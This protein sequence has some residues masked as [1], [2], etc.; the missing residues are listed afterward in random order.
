MGDGRAKAFALSLLTILLTSLAGAGCE[1]AD[2][3]GELGSHLAAPIAV[4]VDAAGNRAYVVNSNN[5]QEFDGASLTVLDISIPESPI[6]LTSSSNPIAIPNFSGQIYFDAATKTAFVPNRLSEDTVDK[7][8]ALLQITLDE[9]SSSFG[10]VTS[11]AGGDSPFGIAC[12]DSSG[13]VTVVSNGGTVEVYNPADLSTFVQISL[14]LTLT[15]GELTT[16]RNSTESVHL[17]TQAFVTN[18]AG[19]IYLLNTTEVGDTSKN[20]IDYVILSGGDLRGIATDGALLYVVDG[21]SSAP[22]LRVLNPATLIPVDPDS[23]TTSEVDI[24]TVQSTTVAVGSDPNEVVILN[25]RAFVSNRGDDTVSVID[26]V[27]NAVTAT[28]TVGDEPFGLAAFT[29]GTGTD[30]LYV[31]NLASNSLSVIDVA[32]N[33]LVTTLAP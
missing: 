31:T 1:E 20:P 13:R 19:K 6:L 7:Q 3:F 4:A 30:L 24:T 25:G 8:D 27:S 32:T 29:T 10:T 26:L 23:A 17:G 16:G 12:C 18:R 22:V 28:I 9:A 11:F 21:T 14:T 33:S 15:S 2:L 5:R